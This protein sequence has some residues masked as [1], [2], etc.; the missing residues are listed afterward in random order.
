MKLPPLSYKDAWNAQPDG[1]SRD[2]LFQAI[3]DSIRERAGDALSETE[4]RLAAYRLISFCR[5]LTGL[6]QEETIGVI[7]PAK[8]SVMVDGEQQ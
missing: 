3:V 1:R 2:E 6:S 8:A 7:D 4:A 5:E